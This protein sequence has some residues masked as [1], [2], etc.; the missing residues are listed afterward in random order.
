MD[1]L[2]EASVECDHGDVPLQLSFHVV[3]AFAEKRFQGNPACVV[4]LEK[5]WQYRE[6]E[7]FMQL[8]AR[9][10]DFYQILPCYQCN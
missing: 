2:K 3:D 10:C 5:E 9:L 4:V 6:S 8:F 7:S 1:E